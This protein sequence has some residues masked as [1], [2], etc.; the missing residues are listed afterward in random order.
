[1]R[2]V[3][4]STRFLLKNSIED[5]SPSSLS[6]EKIID[7]VVSSIFERLFSKEYMQ[8]KDVSFLT[9]HWS[10]YS[11]LKNPGEIVNFCRK[12]GRIALENFNESP[13]FYIP[14]TPKIT[15]NDLK[16]KALAVGGKNILESSS[17]AKVSPE[18]FL[19]FSTFS[20]GISLKNGSENE[21]SGLFTGLGMIILDSLSRGLGDINS[22][23]GTVSQIPES[24]GEIYSDEVSDFLHWTTELIEINRASSGTQMIGNI[25]VDVEKSYEK[26]IR[27]IGCDVGDNG[28]LLEEIENIGKKAAAYGTATLKELVIRT[29]ARLVGKT[30]RIMTT[31]DLISPN[32]PI[33]ISTRK[34][35][36][37]HWKK[38]LIRTIGRI[39]YK[40][41][42]KNIYFLEN[43]ASIGFTIQA[44]NSS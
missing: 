44:L 5:K 34:D 8:K 32:M 28:D 2:E 36:S 43:P 39:G 7:I 14:N 24:E 9:A 20:S 17:T 31:E 21:I 11:K 22:G 30:I 6:V 3:S 40:K 1:M 38:E 15:G 26:E 29:F 42:G 35:L 27:L 19:D 13:T 37:K 4:H 10:D 16:N 12:I 33:C 25:P 23:A 18:I 41:A